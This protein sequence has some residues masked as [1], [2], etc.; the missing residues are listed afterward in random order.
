ML[1]LLPPSEGKSA[2]RTG[3]PVRLEE[4][5]FAG[6]NDARRAVLAALKTVSGADDAHA[7]LGVGASLIEDVQRNLVLD[8]APAAPA[9]DVY[10][11]VLYDALGYARMTPVQK[12]KAREQ[13]VVVSA[14]W[15]ALGFGDRIPAYRL[16]MSVDLPGTGRLASYW[17]KHLA[18][19]L[20]EHAGA[21]LIVDCRSST[22]AAAWTP[23]PQQSAA[24]NVFQLR[25]GRRTVVSHFAKHTRGEFARHLLTRRGAAPATPAALLAAAREKWSAELEPATA[26]KPA[27]LNIV[28]D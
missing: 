22:Y 20:G 5:H 28:L 17:K 11:G 21:G 3:G 2:A 25:G 4:L 6:L 9:H 10:S 1:I 7:V 19:P 23:P 24:V 12:R 26:R 16:S 27:Q 18:V 14:L 13:C 8:V 15:G